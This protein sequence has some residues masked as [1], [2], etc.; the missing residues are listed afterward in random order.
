MIRNGC[1]FGTFI[2]YLLGIILNRVFIKNQ[3]LYT[4]IL[5]DIHFLIISLI[6]LINLIIGHRYDVLFHRQFITCVLKS[7]H[8]DYEY[9]VLE[10]IKTIDNYLVKINHIIKFKFYTIK[11]VRKAK[12]FLIELKDNDRIYIQT[13]KSFFVKP[14]FKKI[15]QT[16]FN[17]KVKELTLL[18][19]MM[20]D[21][22][23]EKL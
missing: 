14:I 9:E 16:F 11:G 1:C 3:L 10:E 2:L 6:L 13:E 8:P 18:K 23:E 20:D 7:V 17:Q 15:N 5:F 4:L 19:Q 21:I 22:I 12:G